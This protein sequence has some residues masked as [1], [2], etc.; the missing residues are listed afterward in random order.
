[1]ARTLAWVAYRDENGTP[2]TVSLHT[3][4]LAASRRARDLT[5]DTGLFHDIVPVAHDQDVSD[6]IAEQREGSKPSST[7]KARTPK[8]KDEGDQAAT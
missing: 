8:P 4:E 5:R 6:A 3:N 2:I 7:P 1:M